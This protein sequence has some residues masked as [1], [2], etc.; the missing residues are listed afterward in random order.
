MISGTES[1]AL[2]LPELT[3]IQIGEYGK[4]YISADRNDWSV[5]IDYKV[6]V[7]MDLD[8][9]L[10]CGVPSTPDQ[11]IYLYFPIYDEDLPNLERLHAIARFAADLCKRGESILTH[12][13]LGL[14]RSALL[15]GVILTYLGLSGEAAIELLRERRPGAL[16][17]DTFADYL[18]SLPAQQ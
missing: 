8:G 4:L 12:C 17:N 9:D 2:L 14:N 7:L 10:D 3:I 6:A 16:Y 11:I 13:K 15:V 18:R 1:S 5:V